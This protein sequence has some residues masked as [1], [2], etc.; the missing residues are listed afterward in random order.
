MIDANWDEE[1]YQIPNRRLGEEEQCLWKETSMAEKDGIEPI[2]LSIVENIEEL[3]K[4]GEEDCD[5]NLP[6]WNARNFTGIAEKPLSAV[7]TPENS[8][9]DP[10]VRTLQKKNRL[11]LNLTK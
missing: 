1:Y 7:R 10:E 6:S 4:E 2:T 9:S 5:G 8:I 11:E 3:E